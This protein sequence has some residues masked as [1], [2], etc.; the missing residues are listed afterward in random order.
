[1]SDPHVRERLLGRPFIHP[2]FDYAVIGGGLSL[3]VTALLVAAPRDDLLV[4]PATM[5]YLL[6]FCTSAHFA[7]STVRLYTKPGAAEGMPILSRWVPWA[8]FALLVGILFL[9][10]T[11]GRLIDTLYLA[12]SPYHYAAQ[13]YGLAVVYSYRSGCRLGPLDKRGLYWVAMLPFFFMA[14]HL[15]ETRLPEFTGIAAGSIAAITLPA[16]SVLRIAGWIAPAALYAFVWR[17][18]GGP[19]PLIALMTLVSNAVWF[20]VLDP[21]NAFLWATIFHG[22]QY[23][24]I[25]MIFDARD[26]AARP[27][28][29]R[30]P[31]FHALWFYG[32]SLVLGYALFVLMPLLGKWAGFEYYDARLVV[33]ALVNIHHFVV[34]AY[35]WRLGRGDS[36]RAIVGGVA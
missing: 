13:A 25:V 20:F 34:D 5:S 16:K 2:V 27:G 36:N 30:G 31:W 12:W 7:A 11:A 8:A 9:G 33:V 17:R 32:A 26:Q 15:A 18:R 14:L 29:A 19:M 4:T 28:N 1:V 35:I 10:G 21:I 6:L 24:A 22:L 3:L 23:M